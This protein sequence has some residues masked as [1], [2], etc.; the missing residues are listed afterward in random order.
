MCVQCNPEGEVQ[1]V[2]LATLLIYKLTAC[3]LFVLLSCTTLP[4]V[5]PACY[6]RCFP[7]HLKSHRS[8]DIVLLCV[9]CHQVRPAC[10]YAVMYTCTKQKEVKKSDQRCCCGLAKGLQQGQARLGFG[11]ELAGMGWD[12]FVVQCGAVSKPEHSW[13]E[14][15]CLS[16]P[17]AL[18]NLCRW[19]TKQLSG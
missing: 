11:E 14:A 3:P 7:Q 10:V 8:H 17:P 4:R 5:V 15:V 18:L 16:A 12:P 9:D 1:P 19:R 6:R 2:A 13:C